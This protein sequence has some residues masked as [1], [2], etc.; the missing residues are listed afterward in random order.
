[1]FDKIPSINKRLFALSLLAC[2]IEAA[3]VL[4]QGLVMLNKLGV[5]DVFQALSIPDADKV[6]IAL[7][8]T[9]ALA[10]LFLILVSGSATL[11]GYTR[12]GGYT[13]YIAIIINLS[14]IVSP[15]ILGYPLSAS[16]SAAML[17]GAALSFALGYTGLRIRVAEEKAMFL[18]PVEIGFIAVF[19]ALTAVIT[20][21]TGIML[22][23]PT[24]GYTNIG[25]TVI[26]LAALLLGSKVGG[27]V[28]VIGPVVA[29]LVIGYPRWFVTVF[30]HGSEGFIA[31]LGRGRN[32]VIQAVL[33]CASGFI[34]AT[35]YF[36]V[37]IFLKGYPI[38]IISY[39][40]DLFGQALVS[41]ILGLILTKAVEKS[42][43]SIRR[44]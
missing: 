12:R 28:G 29:D 16:G 13:A 42:L 44:K 20:G 14:V 9:L 18:T 26:F 23:S 8:L 10:T 33:L 17:V 24:G 21:S 37:N 38:A 22:P 36:V 41:I 34:M 31:G 25:D 6:N 27:L 39:F 35:T 11:K 15:L 32:I 4:L 43:P 5:K 1:M 3:G 19:S 30:A 2:V 40:R 7:F